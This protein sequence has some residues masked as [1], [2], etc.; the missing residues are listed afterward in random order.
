MVEQIHLT[1]ALLSI[2]G[3]FFP[4]FALYAAYAN[5]VGRVLYILGYTAL[6]PKWRYPGAI[7]SGLSTYLMIP[8]SLY[9]LVSHIL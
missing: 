1:I 2:L 3:L 6:G 4:Q 9:F 7:I 8:L 5:V